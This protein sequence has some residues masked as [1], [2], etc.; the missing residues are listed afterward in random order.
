[1]STNFNFIT[2]I[3][4]PLGQLKFIPTSAFTINSITYSGVVVTAQTGSAFNIYQRVNNGVITHNISTDS[5]A[6]LTFLNNMPNLPADV[7]A[8]IGNAPSFL[9]SISS[10]T[11]TDINLTNTPPS[12]STVNL[13]ITQSGLYLGN[14]LFWTQ[15]SN[16]LIAGVGSTFTVEPPTYINSSGGGGGGGSGITVLYG[17]VSAT[18]PGIVPATL[19]TVNYTPGTYG[20][21]IEI[22]II[23]VDNKGRTTF[24][25]QALAQSTNIPNSIVARDNSGDFSANTINANLNGN[26]A[27]VTTNANLTGPITSVG[28]ATAISNNVITDVMVNINAG[29]QDTKL[30]TI[31]TAGKVANSATTADSNDTANAIVREIIAAIL[32]PML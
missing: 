29:I 3:T 18:G 7:A 32:A 27:T 30:A 14:D 9:T 5:T 15:T 25:S 2:T 10:L 16:G 28:N 17:D 31:T 12:G 20:G 24:S 11:V 1:M 26:A 19:S 4:G 23:T 6:F 8:I 13:T 21:N 22:P